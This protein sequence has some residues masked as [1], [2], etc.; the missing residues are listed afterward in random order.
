MPPVAA[1]LDNRTYTQRRIHLVVEFMGLLCHRAESLPRELEACVMRYPDRVRLKVCDDPGE[2][3]FRVLY[4]GI[5][6]LDDGVLFSQ[7]PRDRLLVTS[8]RLFA[9]GG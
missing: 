1:R 2:L 6:N 7:L 8:Q 3:V 9:F 4:D 5:S